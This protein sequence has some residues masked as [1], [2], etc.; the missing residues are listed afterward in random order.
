MMSPMR[1][2]KI[3][4]ERVST[5]IVGTE[6]LLYDEAQ[7][8]A[9]CLNR[10]S[11]CIWRLC[12]GQRSVEEISSA[13]AT[14]LEAPVTEEIVLLTLAELREKNLLQPESAP[15][16]EG[17]SRRQM[18]GRTGLAAAALLPVVASV[19]APSTSAQGVGGSVTGMSRQAET[20]RDSLK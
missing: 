2:C 17:M 12:N 14:E 1:P 20:L 19:L 11:A 8:K 6:T 18:L 16:P 9:W 4:L 5:Q 3:S 15:L 10:S 7:H 13:A